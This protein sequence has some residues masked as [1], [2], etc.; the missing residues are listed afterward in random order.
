[1]GNWECIKERRDNVKI[2][3]C[4]IRGIPACY[5]GFET[6]AQALSL[7]LVEAGH[8]V[9]VYGRKHVIS[10]KEPTFCG[11]NIKLLW[12]PQHKYLET[13]V[14]TLLSLL[15][16]LLHRVDVVLV[17][18]AANS[19]FIWILRCMRIPVVVNVDGVERKRAKWNAAGRMWYRL[20]ELCSVLFASKIV[21]DAQ[22]I[23]EYYLETYKADSTV[24]A[25]G[26]DTS[27]EK[28]VGRK[29][30]AG[31]FLPATAQ[32]SVLFQ[33]LN[34]TRGNYILFVSRLE[35]EN[36]AH[37]VIESYRALLAHREFEMPLVIVGDAPY[38][39]AYK[40]RLREL[41]KGLNVIFAGFRFG[42]HYR[43][44][45]L[46]A[47][48]YIQATEVGGTHPALVEA[49]GF[50]NCVVANRTPENVEVLGSAG[51]FYNMNSAEHLSSLLAELSLHPETV[52]LCRAAAWERA[53]KHY[54]WSNISKSYEALFAS[55][56]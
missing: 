35:P 37:V 43:A 36:N 3:I 14:H 19:P 32:D 30:E 26:H 12:A 54:N 1:M 44:L 16:I 33:E 55:L 22:V 18:N 48:V 53:K 23:R 27:L 8:S 20:G 4:G 11:V 51:R 50:G 9:V 28:Q 7:R 31:E 6:F 13:P 52:S 39:D 15:H 45:Q 5:G 40:S 42:E 41:A 49:M 29:V 21:S 34:I 25:Y 10:H 24:I 46:G 17:C 38:A 47:W 2:A 56:C